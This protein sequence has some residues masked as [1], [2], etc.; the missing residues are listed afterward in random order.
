MNDLAF[1]LLAAG[2]SRRL[3]SPKQL[4]DIDGTP[5]VAHIAGRLLSLAPR[6][7]IV[8]VGSEADRVRESLI[9]LSSDPGRLTTV[10][11]ARWADGIGS[12]IS[13]GVS[14][15]SNRGA[16]GALI[17]LCDQPF[18][19]LAHFEALCRAFATDQPAAVATQYNGSRGVPAIF[20][21]SLFSRLAALAGDQGAKVI[22]ND[23]ALRV[24]TIS[25]DEAR[26][27]LDT[28]ADLEALR[29]RQLGQS[30]PRSC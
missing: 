14:E 7:L 22:L 30:G 10:E 19:P 1:I 5:L 2:G 16:G 13:I 9:P 8:V 21:H 12:S 3:G 6:R 23:A 27:D 18:V 29:S 11:N 20:S 17:A 24:A 15:A 28:P 4:I 25:C 26:W